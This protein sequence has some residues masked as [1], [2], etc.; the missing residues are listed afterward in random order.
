MYVDVLHLKPILSQ[1]ND[2]ET[3]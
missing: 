2:I 3:H 1:P